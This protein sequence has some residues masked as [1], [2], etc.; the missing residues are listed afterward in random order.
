MPPIN[1]TFLRSFTTLM[2]VFTTFSNTT[3]STSLENVDFTRSV[4]TGPGLLHNSQLPYHY[5][6]I[7]PFD[8][9]TENL[10]N[11]SI[12][13]PKTERPFRP[14]DL[15]TVEAELTY[16]SGGKQLF[17]TVVLS[18]GNGQYV[19]EI[20]LRNYFPMVTFRI[21]A[22]GQKIETISVNNV[23]G[24]DCDCPAPSIEK[25]MEDHDC[26]SVLQHH[27]A[28]L[29][30]DFRKFNK[31]WSNT[32]DLDLAEHKF[33]EM[34]TGAGH[35]YAVCKY[36]IKNNE[37]FRN[38]AG[39]HVGFNMFSDEY[40]QA[41]TRSM[42]L[43]DL[44]FIQNLGDWPLSTKRTGDYPIVSWCGSDATFDLVLPTYDYTR[45]VLQGNMKNDFFHFE[46]LNDD[47]PKFENKIDKAVFRGRDSNQQRLDI[48]E[49]SKNHPDL[50]DSAIT[51]FFFFPKDETIK[52]ERIP[53]GDFAKYKYIISLDGTVAAYRMPY[54]LAMDSVI[55]K[56]ESH[57]YEHFYRGLD[58][59]EDNNFVKVKRDV[60]DMKKIIENLK[61]IEEN[62]L[63][64]KIR[65]T[66]KIAQTLLEP[67]SVMC[68]HAEFFR[69]WGALQNRKV[70]KTDDDEFV[71][72]RSYYKPKCV[73][74]AKNKYGHESVREYQNKVDN[75]RDEL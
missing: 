1:T 44:E 36:T 65:K 73:D 60:T 16:S 41:L 27:Q 22:L 30:H 52:K 10:V 69:R 12:I 56:Q 5:F 42:K 46:S 64:E 47:K 11:S 3:S 7:H 35:G 19:V 9:S 39:K 51:A 55:I 2:F 21:H 49:L 45:T 58:G 59:K 67:I 31:Q 6:Y 13:N 32:I 70:K 26:E 72:S 18:R 14:T 66:R 62:V 37:I 61:N 17:Q 34:K 40:L 4:I 25:W 48:S 23:S 43:P 28:Q 75:G 53:M 57:F 68:Y 50:V 29:N 71:S 38:C 74:C 63:V 8:K 24:L 20:K 15:F 54:L 33:Q